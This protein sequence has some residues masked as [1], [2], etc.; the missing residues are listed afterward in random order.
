MELAGG[1]N[2]TNANYSDAPFLITNGDEKFTPHLLSSTD[3]LLYLSNSTHVELH[4]VHD[5]ETDKII[6][7]SIEVRF[8]N[9]I[10]VLVDHIIT[11]TN[12]RVLFFTLT[13]VESLFNNTV[14][15]IGTFNGNPD[16]DF[17]LPNGT[18]LSPNLTT[19]EIH[20][21]FGLKWT[22]PE[23][24]SLFYYPENT[25]ASEFSNDSFVPAFEVDF[26]MFSADFEVAA[27]AVCGD[28]VFCL[29]DA[30]GTGLILCVVLLLLV[31]NL[32]FTI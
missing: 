6:N 24:E 1:Y 8:D 9:G 25:S 12:M 16:D 18:V 29:M 11:E 7:S 27:R 15:L 10:M 30:A 13:V 22:I 14:G 5:K 20:Y 23:N 26:S 28:D 31:F 2:A 32:T 21:K 17:T 4:S 19:E 3:T